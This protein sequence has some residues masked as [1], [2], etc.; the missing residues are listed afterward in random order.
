ML[1]GVAEEGGI[2]GEISQSAI[3]EVGNILPKFLLKCIKV[4][5]QN[6]TIVPSTPALAY[7][8]AGEYIK[9]DINRVK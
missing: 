6:L 9:Y 8:I 4:N 7:D 5:L 1:L 3:M 2:T